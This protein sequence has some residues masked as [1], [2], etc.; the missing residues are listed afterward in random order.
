MGNYRDLRAWQKAHELT[1]TIYRLTGSFPKEELF[2]L[3]SQMR[4]AAVSIGANL[5]E[6]C[7]RRGD[8]DLRRFAQ[9]SRGSAKELEYL[10]QV[11]AELGLFSP[12]DAEH[13]RTSTEE[14]SRMLSKLIDG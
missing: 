8:G 1:L 6:G 3:T 12:A 11:S 4:R 13:I 9:I 7:G 2:G 14:L 10:A 5:A